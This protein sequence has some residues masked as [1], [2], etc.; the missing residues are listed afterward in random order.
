M[1][2]LRVRDYMRKQPISFSPETQVAA[3]VEALL[4]QK[5]LGAPV[6]DD[7][8]KV[9]GWVS[10]Q[11]CLSRVLES[12]YHSERNAIVSDVM[13]TEVLSITPDL[14]IVD[15]AQQMTKDKPKIYPVLDE[16]GC[17]IGV[18]SRR[19]V[20]G[21]IDRHIRTSFFQTTKQKVYR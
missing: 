1:E 12:T 3:A 13:S 17:L 2:S 11:D 21:A 6:L 16:E 19:D 9:I 8:R 4:E 20:L 15:L 7:K 14:G 5:Q 18:I 10:E